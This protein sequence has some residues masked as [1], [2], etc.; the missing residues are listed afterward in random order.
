MK[1][2]ELKKDLFTVE[3]TYCLAHCISSDCKMGAG[4]AVEFQKRFK[5][6]EI[7][8][9]IPEEKRKHPTCIKTGRVF[10]L[11]T[12]EKYWGKPTYET[13]RA[14]LLVMKETALNGNVKK[15]AM[16]I[17]GSDLDKLEWDKVMGI[18]MDVFYETEIEILVCKIK[19]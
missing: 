4:I 6:K 13:M 2:L 3:G 18:I 8:L 10:N 15:I 5:V 19:K 1:Y 17:I 7:L 11:I 16:P 12:K 9:K 14:A